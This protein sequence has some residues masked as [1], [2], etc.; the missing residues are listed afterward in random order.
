MAHGGRSRGETGTAHLSSGRPSVRAASLGPDRI[1]AWQSHPGAMWR[2]RRTPIAGRSTRDNG[3]R[4]RHAPVRWPVACATELSPSSRR[5][6][7]H[8]RRVRRAPRDA[9]RRPGPDRPLRIQVDEAKVARV[10][11]SKV[12]PGSLGAAVTASNAFGLKLYGLVERDVGAKNLLTSPL[13]ASLALTMTYAGAAGQ[14]GT[15]MAAALQFDPAPRARSSTG[16]NALGQALA[17]RGADAF[18]TAQQETASPTSLAASDYHRPDRQRGPGRAHLPLAGAFSEHAGRGLRHGRLP[19]KTSSTRR[20]GAPRHQR[21][22]QQR[23][24]RQ[25]Q[26]PLAPDVDRRQDPHGPRGRA[27]PEIPV[28]DTPFDAS[29]TTAGTFTCGDG[30]PS[31]RSS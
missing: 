24:R 25:D 18:A 20:P 8:A 21:L 29:L 10:P 28:A 12:S 7:G 26:R 11:A 4:W 3:R 30:P 5:G 15:E 19:W 22:G 9:V 27:A 6:R 13:S 31:R 2:N 23:H 1:A 17:S 14:T 16:R